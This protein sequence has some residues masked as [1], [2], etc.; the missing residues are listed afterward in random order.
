MNEETL[1]T[2][3]IKRVYVPLFGHL[4]GEGAERDEIEEDGEKEE[5]V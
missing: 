2:E 3:G 5:G 1:M 4:E